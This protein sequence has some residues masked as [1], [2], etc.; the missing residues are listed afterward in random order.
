M[1]K[2]RE[3]AEHDEPVLS[4]FDEDVLFKHFKELHLVCAVEKEVGA[5]DHLSGGQ[6]NRHDRHNKDVA[7]CKFVHL[8]G[9]EQNSVSTVDQ[10][11]DADPTLI[12]LICG[13][14]SV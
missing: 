2:R 14:W 5:V 9:D 12:S 1:K 10:E 11:S 13:S 6:L 4:L 7:S 8:V 3:N